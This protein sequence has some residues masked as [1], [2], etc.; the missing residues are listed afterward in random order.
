M[1]AEEVQDGIKPNNIRTTQPE[2]I[3]VDI[4]LIGIPPFTK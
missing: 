3:L 4:S 1:E 2:A